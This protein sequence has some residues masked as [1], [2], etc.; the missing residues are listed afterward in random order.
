MDLPAKVGAEEEWTDHSIADIQFGL[1]M[2]KIEIRRV[3]ENFQRVKKDNVQRLVKHRARKIIDMSFTARIEEML[4]KMD[5]IRIIPKIRMS[6]KICRYPWKWLPFLRLNDEDFSSIRSLGGPFR[7]KT[8]GSHTFGI[9]IN[10]NNARLNTG[11]IH[12]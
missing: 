10:N 1:T 3:R 2:D 4:S 8:T 6:R 12:Y 7:V 9:K 11:N 5:S